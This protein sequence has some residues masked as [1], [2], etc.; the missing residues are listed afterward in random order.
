MM[1]IKEVEF[2]Y[3]DVPLKEIPQRNM[4][5]QLH[6]WRIFQ[7]C[8]IELDN[9]VE[10]FGETLPTYTWSRV[11]ENVTEKLKGRSPAEFLWDDSLG[12]GVQMAL[13]DVTGKAMGVPA[14]QLMGAKHRDFCPIS[15]WAIDMPP[16]DYA[17][18]ARE[19]VELGYTSMKQ[20][21]RPWFDVYEQVKQTAASSNENFKIDLDF[22]GH[23]V[24]SAN[25]VSVI[26]KLEK[27]PNVAFL[28]SPIPQQDV[29]GNQRIRSQTRCAIAMHFGNPP[30]P[31]AVSEQVCDG[32]VIG[33]GAYTT[34][35][36]F[37]CAARFNLPG[38]LQ[39]VG[40]GITT[41][42][43]LHLGCVATHAQWP[44]ITCVN[45]Y[46]HQLISE[47]IE[48]QGGFAK[49]PDSPGLGIKLADDFHQFK[50]DSPDKPNVR[51]H[52]ALVR[53]SGD[54]RWFQPEMSHYGYWTESERGNF[55]GVFE[56][57]VN[58]ERWDDDGSK[59]WKD[60]EERLKNG[61]VSQRA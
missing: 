54:K 10:G 47:Q 17:A 39:L 8:R 58:L 26:R 59:E 13:F 46:Q 52:Y 41:T 2:F 7:I 36:Q 9:G 51:A 43:G 60:M 44:M 3:V 37:A 49:V 61:P 30:F 53:A 27:C 18:Q 25:A 24:N 11:Q 48:I 57:G 14:Y 38:W 34:L 32:F 50:V 22:N 19:A 28:E 29:A 33:G 23:L 35:H 56:H 15:W 55:P 20:K 40:T 4:E 12:A 31:T 1:K 42:W 16:E 5:R 6:G 45:M 21:P